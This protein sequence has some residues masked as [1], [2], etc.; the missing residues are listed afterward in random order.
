M[1]VFAVL[2]ST[3]PSPDTWFW[4]FLKSNSLL[5]WIG[6]QSRCFPSFYLTVL[7]WK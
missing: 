5:E 7:L 4:S 1:Q 3:V 6:I 2:G